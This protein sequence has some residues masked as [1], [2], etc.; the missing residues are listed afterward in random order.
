MCG[1]E[2]AEKFEEEKDLDNMSDM[3]LNAKRKLLQ[4]RRGDLQAEIEMVINE[5]KEISEEEFKRNTADK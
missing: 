2:I 5:L 3:E 4:D 1:L